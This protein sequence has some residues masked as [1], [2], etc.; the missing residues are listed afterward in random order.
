MRIKK[1]AGSPVYLSPMAPQDA[2]HYAIWLNDLTVTR[3]LTL[4]GVNITLESE[5]AAI[6]ELNK[7]HNYAIVENGND[8]L[9]GGCG[10]MDIDHVHGTAMIGIFIGAAADRGKGLG[11]EAMGLL[12]DY[13]FRYLNLHN[14]MLKVF[15]FNAA[16]IRCYEKLG[17]RRIGSRRQALLRERQRHDEIYMDLLPEDFYR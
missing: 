6:T 8:R 4:P 14:I 13:G 11:G 7:G 16:G 2:P 15:S 12:I 1:L 10:L 9:L 3:N 5:L 17:F